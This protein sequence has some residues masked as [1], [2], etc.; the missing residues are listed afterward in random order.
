KQLKRLQADFCV[1]WKAGYQPPRTYDARNE[2]HFWSDDAVRYVPGFKV[3]SFE[4]G[5]RFSFE[6]A[7]RLC[8]EMNGG[9][10]PFG[11]HAWQ[12]HD[13]TFWEP[14]LLTDQEQPEADV[15]WPSGL[16]EM[17]ALQA[18]T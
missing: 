7:P 15:T 9:R 18:A 14:Y 11:C 3:A 8:F 4:T 10:L 12:K 16:P 13:R 5:L 1:R 6:V 2:D 17:Q